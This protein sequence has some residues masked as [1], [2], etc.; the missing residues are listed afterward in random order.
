MD[1]STLAATAMASHST[2]NSQ[3]IQ[4]A[5]LK[6]QHNQDQN[7]VNMLAQSAENTKAM[8]AAGIGNRVDKSA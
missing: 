4:I 5:L 2:Q 7:L 8:T 6:Q 1:V 3:N